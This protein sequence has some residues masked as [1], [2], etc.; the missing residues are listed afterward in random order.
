[1]CSG[2][3]ALGGL[4]MSVFYVKEERVS[5]EEKGFEKSGGCLKQLQ[6]IMP[7][8]PCLSNFPSLK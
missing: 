6:L 1:M 2:P 5:L 3:S 4:T 7:L 8:Y